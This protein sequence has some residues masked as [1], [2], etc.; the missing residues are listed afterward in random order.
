MNLEDSLDKIKASIAIMLDLASESKSV[1]AF[2]ARLYEEKGNTL[3]K[4]S[5]GVDSA[6][7]HSVKALQAYNTAHAM[8]EHIKD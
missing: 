8:L 3:M 1:D 4:M 7:L 2:L 6:D 5:G